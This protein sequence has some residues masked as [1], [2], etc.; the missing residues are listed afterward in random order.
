MSDG[1]TKH[2][3]LVKI[4]LCMVLREVGGGGGGGGCRG[5]SRNIPCK[6]SAP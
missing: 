1:I 4:S 3:L 6:R 5:E 2:F